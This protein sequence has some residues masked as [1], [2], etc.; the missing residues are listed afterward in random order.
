MDGIK[1]D[2]MKLFKMRCEELDQACS[3]FSS[4]KKFIYSVDADEDYL[5]N[6]VS[7]AENLFSYLVVEFDDLHT[8]MSKQ[9][10]DA[11]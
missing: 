9:L 2:Y 5:Y 10:K 7:A 1:I 3:L 11:M 8:N 4:I 6:L